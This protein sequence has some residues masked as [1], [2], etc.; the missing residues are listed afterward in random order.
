ML[1]MECRVGCMDAGGVKRRRKEEVTVI[2]MSYQQPLIIGGASKYQHS[3]PTPTIQ[4][5]AAVAT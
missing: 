1:V 5:Q 3:L 2:R 4:K